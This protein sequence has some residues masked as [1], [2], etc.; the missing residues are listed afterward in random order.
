[1]RN[2][3]N[4]TGRSFEEEVRQGEQTVRVKCRE[5]STVK[6]KQA[7]DHTD[8]LKLRRSEVTKLMMLC[9]PLERRDE[10]HGV[11]QLRWGTEEDGGKGKT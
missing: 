8:M 1:V 6:E 7:N 5:W 9:E 4:A 3:R 2:V 11:R 10:R